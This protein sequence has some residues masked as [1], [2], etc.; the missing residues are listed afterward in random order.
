M[1]WK[2]LSIIYRFF[3]IYFVFIFRKKKKTLKII[4]NAFSSTVSLYINK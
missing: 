3:F 4:D 2:L 1:F